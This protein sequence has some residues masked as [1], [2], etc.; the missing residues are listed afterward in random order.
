M[1]VPAAGEKVQ[2]APPCIAVE[3]IAV[4]R[5]EAADPEELV[6]QVEPLSLGPP[7]ESDAQDKDVE[8]HLAAFDHC[9]PCAR[10]SSTSVEPYGD[11]ADE[12]DE[13]PRKVFDEVAP[14]EDKS[15]EQP[16][17]VSGHAGVADRK[18]IRTARDLAAVRRR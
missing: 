4:D 18:E 8:W 6:P 3:Q 5:E 10:A 1:S 13:Q 11:L 9:Y 16:R 7:I 15:L 17:A 12:H 2:S 14:R